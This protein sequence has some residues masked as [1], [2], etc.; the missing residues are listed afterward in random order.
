MN[1]DFLTIEDVLAIH[2]D[3][4]E[5]YGGDAGVRDIGLLD[6]AIAQTKASFGGAY[7][8]EDVYAMA[9][10]YL[11]HIVQNHPFIDGNKRTGAVA[12]L[13][14]FDINGVE[15]NVPVGSLY[16][17]VIGIAEGRI[18]KPAIAA[19]LRSWSH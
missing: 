19:T 6:S 8:H 17:L 3:Q 14:F 16:D 18:D 11:F 10:A 5:R 2:A 15:I 12:A 1:I 4:V 9:A 7:L 13:L